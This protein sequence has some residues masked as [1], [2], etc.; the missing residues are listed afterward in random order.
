MLVSALDPFL[1][2]QHLEPSY[3]GILDSAL[4]VDLAAFA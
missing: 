4:A 1:S 2:L 3:V